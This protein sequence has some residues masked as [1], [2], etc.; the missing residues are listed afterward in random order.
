MY[1]HYSAVIL[2]VPKTHSGQCTVTQQAM[3]IRKETTGLAA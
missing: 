3:E 1:R 2:S